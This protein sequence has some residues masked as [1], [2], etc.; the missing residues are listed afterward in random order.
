VLYS[1]HERPLHFRFPSFVILTGE[2]NLF[3]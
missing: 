1:L 3:D 2:K